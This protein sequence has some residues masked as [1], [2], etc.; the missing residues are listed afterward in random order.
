MEMRKNNSDNL[1]RSASVWVK[2]SMFGEGCSKPL[3]YLNVQ[4]TPQ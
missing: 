3:Q 4:V 2:V 1:G